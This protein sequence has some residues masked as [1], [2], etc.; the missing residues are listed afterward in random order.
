MEGSWSKRPRELGDQQFGLLRRRAAAASPVSLV[1]STSATPL[2]DTGTETSQAQ[3]RWQVVLLRQRSGDGPCSSPLTRVEANCRPRGTKIGSGM[4]TVSEGSK[5]YSE[6]CRNRCSNHDCGTMTYGGGWAIRHSSS[7]ELHREPDRRL[8]LGQRTQPG[9]AFVDAVGVDQLRLDVV[10]SVRGG[11]YPAVDD[12]PVG[13]QFALASW[14]RN[15]RATD[16][17]I[18]GVAPSSRRGSPSRSRR[19]CRPSSAEAGRCWPAVVAVRARRCWSR[20]T[21]PLSGMPTPQPLSTRLAAAR[22]ETRT[23]VRR[24]TG[25]APARPRAPAAAGSAAASRQPAGAG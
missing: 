13:C 12:H 8:A 7:V 20:W 24:L 19:A 10:V 18:A 25:P 2:G 16:V 1:S 15:S 6:T 5:K 23:A 21:C 11:E 4:S 3:P 14:V 17:R 22:P 9:A